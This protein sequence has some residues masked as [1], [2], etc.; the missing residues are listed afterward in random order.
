V[1]SLF[2]PGVIAFGLTLQLSEA[3]WAIVWAGFLRVGVVHHVT[4]SINSICHIFG[5]R[6]FDVRDLSTNC[7]LLALYFFTL[8]ESWHHNHHAF[9]WSARHGLVDLEFE[10]SQG[11][12]KG[13]LR[14]LAK[15]EPDPSWMLIRILKRFRLVWDVK[16]PSAEDIEAKRVSQPVPA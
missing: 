12:R 9:P 7:K 5:K 13:I 6:P 15:W 2:L 3:L 11:V 8:G 14:R 4:W 1:V 10:P 16:V